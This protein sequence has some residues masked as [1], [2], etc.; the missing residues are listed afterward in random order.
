LRETHGAVHEVARGLS[1]PN[2]MQITADGK[3]LICSD[4]LA[5]R[6]VSYDI[7]EDGTLGPEQVYAVFECMPDG[8]T[9]DAEGGLWVALPPAHQARR[10]VDGQVTDT[11]H[12]DD[13]VFDVALGGPNGTHL[14][15]AV[16]NLAE[17]RRSLAEGQ[18]LS[19]PG[20][21]CRVEVDVPGRSLGQGV[22]SE[23][24]QQ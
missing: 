11:V 6:I 1:M 16:S 3:I 8:S 14:Y 23:K 5:H 18:E 9:L 2:T 4:S 20:R 24:G 7:R 17:R 21:V 12:F 19:R 10:L 15:A 22:V 13:E